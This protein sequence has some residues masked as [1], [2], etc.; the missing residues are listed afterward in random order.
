MEPP[1]NRQQDGLSPDSSPFDIFDPQY[2]ANYALYRCRSTIKQS[3]R[4]TIELE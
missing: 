2:P 3:F 4:F 1:R